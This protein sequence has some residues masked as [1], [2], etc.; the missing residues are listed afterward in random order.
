VLWVVNEIN[1]SVATYFWDSESGELRALQI[2][3]LT[4]DDY[5]AENTGSEI[6]VGA[7][8][9]FVYCSNRGHN[10]V[11]IFAADEKTGKLRPIGWSP[12]QGSTPRFI[13]F[14][15]AQRFLYAANEQ[16]D[17]IVAWSVDRS[18][19]RLTPAGKPIKNASPVTIVFGRRP[20]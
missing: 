3:P 16:S 2:V 4:P 18:N 15:P 7:G 12:T 11:G 10:S 5:T 17:T 20:A 14:D 1:S 8:G 19:G 6:A 13:G 9:R